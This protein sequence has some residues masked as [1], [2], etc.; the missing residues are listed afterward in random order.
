M[1]RHW[2]Y[3]CVILSCVFCCG[4]TS[5]SM[6]QLEQLEAQLDSMPDAVRLAL[7]S[8]PFASLN[9]EER[10]L[11]AILRTQA[12]YK[13]YAPLTTDTLIRCYATDFYP[14]N[15]KNYRAAMAWYSL[16]CVY[17]ELKD[18]AGAVEAYLQAQS[19][20]PDTT[21]LYYQLCY[22]NLGRHYLNKNMADEALKAY[23]SYH[24]A[25]EGYDHLYAD[26]GLAKAYIYKRMPQ[27]AKEILENLLQY[28]EEID[29]LSVETILLELGKIAHTFDKD[30][31]KADEYF[32]QLITLY[33]VKEEDPT[34]WF[35]GDIAELRGHSDSARYYYEIAMQGYDD[36][37]LQYNCV[38]SLLYLTIDST[39]QPKLYG[40]IKRFEQMSDSINRI[41]R[42]AEIDEI[43]TVHAIELQ[44]REIAE[45]Y[46]RFIYCAVLIIVC[47][48]ATIVIVTLY[49]EQR[50]KQH[51]LRLRKELQTNQA[52]IY[53]IN[54]SIEEN[55]N[56]LPYSREEILAIYRDSLNASIALF[57]KSACAMRLQ[58]LNKL[59]NKD[60]GHISIK[61]REELYEALDENF[62]T[63][64]T[65]L[66]DEA[67]KYSQTKLS[68]LNI[69][70]ILL[71]A[72]G[73]STG[74]IREC[75]AVS[76]DN[77]VTQHKKRVLNRLPNDI[78]STLFGAI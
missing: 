69:H 14:G 61:E 13:C 52:K 56:S 71:L 58:K 43:H 22:Q 63:V 29:T 25:T 17:T 76:A 15:Q 9:D 7:D 66:R 42:R 30:Y 57:N 50:R 48:L 78:I 34:Y 49:I 60:V 53:K 33:N 72:M 40:Y 3:I 51:Y 35:K 8:I 67:N 1:R 21:V 10:A 2:H 39:I 64:I 5:P 31:D 20:F 16:G 73:Y 44:Q 19:L 36:V 6:R 62:I 18:D 11:Y 59:R 68:S 70:L 55:G 65:Y 46:R 4:C 23:M 45:Q 54:E 26:I 77:A 74:V 28:R 32:N 27:Q 47:L 38:R 75:L 24:N 41:E 12:D 37:Y